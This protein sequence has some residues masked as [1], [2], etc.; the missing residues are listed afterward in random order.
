MWKENNVEEKRI[1][2][3]LRK[4][5]MNASQKCYYLQLPQRRLKGGKFLQDHKPKK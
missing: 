1:E 3:E 5:D 2:K 4:K